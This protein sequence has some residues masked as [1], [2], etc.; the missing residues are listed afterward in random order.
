MESDIDASF[1]VH[2]R[3]VPGARVPASPTSLD[4]PPPPGHP[5]RNPHA[6]YRLV[7]KDLK[8]PIAPRLSPPERFFSR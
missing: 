1:S 4:R 8:T 2:L 3:S 5:I 6:Q 7:L